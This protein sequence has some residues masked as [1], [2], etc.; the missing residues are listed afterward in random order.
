MTF[1]LAL[2]VAVAI[3]ILPGAMSAAHCDDAFACD[4][5]GYRD[6][7]CHQVCAQLTHVIERVSRSSS[8]VS[9]TGSLL[10]TQCD[11]CPRCWTCVELLSRHY[12]CATRN[13]LPI[14]SVTLNHDKVAVGDF[15]S[16]HLADNAADG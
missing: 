8:R 2:M 14:R 16:L 13:A 4:G 11:C 10:H 15:L 5:F 12:D 9:L 6:G 3:V 7:R 1:S